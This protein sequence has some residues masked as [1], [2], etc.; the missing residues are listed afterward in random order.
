MAAPGLPFRKP[1]GDPAQRAA[2]AGN[3]RRAS[4]AA[5][6]TDAGHQGAVIGPEI[7]GHQQI[8][9]AM[10][11]WTF[12]R[13]NLALMKLPLNSCVALCN[14]FFPITSLAELAA[15]SFGF[16]GPI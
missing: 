5:G 2:G 12:G 8:C 13:Q 7:S 6:A 16:H 4:R 9:H 15:R 10:S 14:S 11:V 1:A 3:S